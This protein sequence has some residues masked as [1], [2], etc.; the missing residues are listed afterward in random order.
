MSQFETRHVQMPPSLRSLT[1]SSQFER[2]REFENRVGPI[3]AQPSYPGLKGPSPGGS[4]AQ[5]TTPTSNDPGFTSLPPPPRRIRAKRVPVPQ[6]VS[7]EGESKTLSKLT[8]PQNPHRASVASFD[9]SI[10]DQSPTMAWLEREGLS[11]SNRASRGSIF[12]H[13]EAA[14]IAEEEEPTAGASSGDATA[15]GEKK[16]GSAEGKVAAAVSAARAALEEAVA[17]AAGTDSSSSKLS[18]TASNANPRSESVRPE[19]SL[20][21]IRVAE[22][23]Y[24]RTSKPRIIGAIIPPSP[25]S[26][27]GDG[28]ASPTRLPVDDRES[29][30]ST[31]A[32]EEN[33]TASPDDA[34]TLDSQEVAP[35]TTAATDHD[36]DIWSPSHHANGSSAT[37]PLRIEKRPGSK[38]ASTESLVAKTPVNAAPKEFIVPR[39]SA[40]NKSET[41][42]ARAKAK[43]IKAKSTPVDMQQLRAFMAGRDGAGRG[44]PAAADSDNPWRQRPLLSHARMASRSSV[45]S[46]DSGTTYNPP[47]TIASPDQPR[48][49]ISSTIYTDSN[50]HGLSAP[51]TANR[52][53]FP[54]D[55]RSFIGSYSSEEGEYN[56]DSF[57]RHDILHEIQSEQI[58]DGDNY[59]LMSILSGTHMLQP[60]RSHS[61]KPPVPRTP[62]PIFS[63]KPLSENSSPNNSP[64]A[65][66]LV[67]E[68]YQYTES[69][70]PPPTTNWL[71]Q[72][73]RA[74]L[75]KK[76]RKL[77]R[78]F[79]RTPGAEVMAYQDGSRS[80]PQVGKSH[81]SKRGLRNPLSID[82]DSS[83]NHRRR[84]S[85]WPSPTDSMF[86]H[87]SGSRRHSLPLS[88]DDIS[89]LNVSS[90]LYDAS[91]SLVA[92]Q[93]RSESVAAAAPSIFS[94]TDDQSSDHI[95]VTHHDNDSPNTVTH[96][97]SSSPSRTSFIDWSDEEGLDDGL[98]IISQDEPS[99][100][101]VVRRPTSPTHS[102]FENM[103]S[104]EQ[105]EEE[106]RRKREKLAKLHRFLGSTVPVNLVVGTEIEN[107]MPGP[108]QTQT[109]RPQ[110]AY[111]TSSGGGKTGSDKDEVDRKAW[112]RR[113]RSS[114]AAALPSNWPDKMDRI[115]EE[116][117]TKE[118]LVNVRRA[119]KMEK[120]FGAAPPQSLYHTRGHTPSPSLPVLLPTAVKPLGNPSAFIPSAEPAYFS[121]NP[122]RSSYDKSANTNGGKLSRRRPN[123]R[124][125]TSESSKQLIP[126]GRRSSSTTSFGFAGSP[127]KD[128]YSQG[129]HDDFRN[130]SSNR[131]S[132]MTSAR[133]PMSGISFNQEQPIG[134]SVIYNHYQHSLKSLNDILDRDDC[135][136]LVEL[137]N[138]LNNEPP[139]NDLLITPDHD[140][141]FNLNPFI[142]H[143]GNSDASSILTER[144]RSLPASIETA[145]IISGLTIGDKDAAATPTD[146]AS[147][148]D[149][150]MRRRRAA[151]LTQFFGVQY[152]ELINDV[153]DSLENGLEHEQK[154]G[155]LQA[156]EIA[157]LLDRLRE[158]KVK[159]ENKA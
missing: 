1:L 103:T 7:E 28:D 53:D 140:E 126:K 113:R 62:K 16:K 50:D 104:E 42:K 48:I 122:N 18:L 151:K 45:R 105:A 110:T 29:V 135:E 56:F 132:A 116:L 109:S 142:R 143:R 138:Y 150:Q 111:S 158:L 115:K 153:L 141:S 30:P 76:S 77:A 88:P 144:R 75:V 123:A 10:I 106:K 58:I 102:F 9:A 36:D 136:S 52:A 156:D 114:S 145:S 139:T 44:Y 40:S 155:T 51:N 43:L 125:G 91:L 73:E 17:A 146:D 3:M 69:C 67:F 26:A 80:T 78:V 92:S 121:R 86:S 64:S 59:Q 85:A 120:V 65:S 97:G 124:P 55:V 25:T 8:I 34:I 79:G 95:S 130:F 100:A 128:T 119:Q 83:S 2:L 93:L 37:L 112:L 39:G 11:K 107:I 152:R 66:S 127:P 20:E 129:H 131:Y 38:G 96:K 35:V 98:S 87:S 12:G 74:D 54:P 46:M 90:P 47:S 15:K 14:T 72:E 33:L 99:K 5:S 157:D 134:A 82:L 61:P 57:P 32:Q 118:K 49:S 71:G 70:D 19:T 154:R 137:H 60:L 27:P 68:G 81:L 6:Y 89:F 159:R 13:V 4:N 22:K 147:I 148:T 101:G 94:Q 108:A 84:A 31:P 23:Q 149:F 24:F 63:R 21:D 41:P 133:S 117:N